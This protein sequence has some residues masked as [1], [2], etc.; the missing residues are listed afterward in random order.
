[1]I[2]RLGRIL[3]KKEV[4]SD[5]YYIYCVDTFEEDYAIRARA[6][7]QDVAEKSEEVIY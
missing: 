3:R 7:V 6:F 2:Q 1:M 5:A 4:P